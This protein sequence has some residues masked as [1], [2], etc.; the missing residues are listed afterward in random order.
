M[1]VRSR[2]P[3]PREPLPQSRDPLRHN[4]F[5]R[6]RKRRKSRQRWVNRAS[7]KS[8]AY[9]AGM[10]SRSPLGWRRSRQRHAAHR[11]SEPAIPFATQGVRRA[12]SGHDDVLRQRVR[13]GSRSGNGISALV[14]SPDHH[15]PVPTD[16]PR[17]SHGAP[18]QFARMSSKARSATGT[19]RRPCRQ[20]PSSRLDAWCGSSCGV[21]QSGRLVRL[22]LR[23]APEWYPANHGPS[24]VECRD[25]M[26]RRL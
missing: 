12:R 6:I 10:Q 5:R 4:A 15:R 16:F 26:W 3:A 8:W 9:P 18:T 11:R 7:L 22:Q 21:P 13:A 24:R 23:E 17:G 14:G 19:P 20:Q 2:S 25:L 1:P